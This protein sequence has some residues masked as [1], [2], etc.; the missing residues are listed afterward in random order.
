VWHLVEAGVA[1]HAVSQLPCWAATLADVV[2]AAD[3]RLASDVRAD[4]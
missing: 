1:V 2:T 3:G 4:T